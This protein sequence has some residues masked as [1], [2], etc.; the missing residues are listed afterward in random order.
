M[1]HPLFSCRSSRGIGLELVRQIAADA[2]N[3]VFATCRNPSSASKLK[4]V[5]E[6]AKGKV[7]IVQLDASDVSS[8]KAAAAT[9]SKALGSHGLNYVINNAAGVRVYNST[10]AYT[11]LT[12]IC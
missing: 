3:V 12:V 8:I 10:S 4:T 2:S 11:I 9:V 1:D 7:H 5:S 6:E